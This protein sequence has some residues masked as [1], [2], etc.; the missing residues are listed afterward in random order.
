MRK[1]RAKELLESM[2]ESRQFYPHD[3]S[4]EERL[5]IVEHWDNYSDDESKTCWVFYDALRDLACEEET[6]QSIENVIGKTSQER[7]ENTSDIKEIYTELREIIL[8]G[9]LKG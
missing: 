8:N 2:R 3:M 6:L 1:E 9:L 4:E 7:S 5:E